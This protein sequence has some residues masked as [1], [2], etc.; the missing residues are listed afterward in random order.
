[1]SRAQSAEMKV[2]DCAP[3]SLLAARQ[4]A[5]CQSSGEKRI[6]ENDVSFGTRLFKRVVHAGGKEERKTQVRWR[7]VGAP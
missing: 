7:S 1:M 5:A 4:E 6:S 3:H 2:G